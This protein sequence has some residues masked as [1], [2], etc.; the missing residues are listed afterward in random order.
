MSRHAATPRFSVGICTLEEILRSDT[1]GLR[2]GEGHV[3][4][5][6]GVSDWHIIGTG[7]A[8]RCSKQPGAAAAA[9]DAV[10]IGPRL[11]AP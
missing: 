4:R 6:T 8:A 10:E 9:R 5:D 7:I 3:L 11:M 1:W 2:N